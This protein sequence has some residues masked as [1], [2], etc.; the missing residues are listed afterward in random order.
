MKTINYSKTKGSFVIKYLDD[1]EIYKG[2]INIDD[3]SL[4]T[5]LAKYIIDNEEGSIFS[6]VTHIGNLMNS[7]DIL[8]IQKDIN[9]VFDEISE[10][11]YFQINYNKNDKFKNIKYEKD[12]NPNNI[13]FQFYYKPVEYKEN[14]TISNKIINGLK[15]YPSV[16]CLNPY[17]YKDDFIF[18]EKILIYNFR[19]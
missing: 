18:F 2:T 6:Y 16:D 7:V 4:K 3:D 12:I 10:D 11:I 15:K 9:I 1:D 5:E 19:Y 8:I 17:G 13:Y 14:G